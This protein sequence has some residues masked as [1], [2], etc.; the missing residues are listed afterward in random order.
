MATI[1]QVAEEAGLSKSTVSRYISQKGYV[2]DEARDK[3]KAG[4]AKLHYSRNVLAQ[5]LKTKKN[6]LVG[7]LLPDISNPFFPRLARGAEEYLKEKGYRVML[8]NISD[9]EA[10]EEEY[11]HVLLQSNAA[12]IIT[13]HDFTKRYPDLPIPVVVVD[14]V[15]Q[16]TQYGV[17]SDN[18][19]G[20][21][22]AAQTVWQAGTEEV[23]LIRGPLDNAENINERFEASLSYLHEKEVTLRIC[24]S[25]SFDF[26]SIQ[27]E[28]SKNL[29]VYPIIDSIIAPS[30]IHAIAYI[31]ELHS[32][33]KKI[34]QD[35]QV[36]GYDDILM[37]QFIYPSLSTI[38]QSSYLM[39][40]YAAEL[41]YNIANQLPVEANR[42]KLPVHYVERETIRRKNE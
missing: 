10:L 30:D 20:G 42:I 15:D 27:L 8:G 34:P 2:S 5:S 17:F 29:D 28:A 3:I 6:Q 24:D 23:L 32:R 11:V 25:Q 39:G 18:K 40:H 22:L 33:G 21:L 16:E 31:H 14:R 26:E 41:V 36:M 1:K 38:H 9:S 7:L 13:T 4:I 12:G 37:S 35:V 19:A